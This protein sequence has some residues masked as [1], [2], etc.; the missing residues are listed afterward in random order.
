M[1]KNGIVMIAM[2]GG[3]D[4]A[5]SAAKLLESGYEVEG[6]HMTNWRDDEPYCTASQDLQDAKNACKEIGIPMHHVDFS[7]EYRKD[8]FDESLLELRSG[9]TPNPDILCNQMIKFDSF[10]QHAKRLGAKKIATGHYAR[11]SMK[12]DESLLLKG[13]DQNK[14]QTYFLH[15]IKASVLDDVLFPVGSMKKEEVRDYAYKKGLPNHDKPD[16]T[17]I[18]FIGERPFKNF[19]Q[20]FLPP[21]PGKIV[22]EDGETLGAHDGLMYF[23]L[24]QRKDIGIGGLKNHSGEPWYVASKNIDTNELLVVQGRNHKKLWQNQAFAKDMNW[25]NDDFRK[26]VLKGNPIACKAKCRYRQADA[27]CEIQLHKDGIRVVFDEDQW[28]ITH[29][30]YLVIYLNDVCMGGGKIFPEDQLTI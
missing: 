2:S 24:G 26:K 13:T 23:T 14:D 28:A 3:V 1:S 18:C 29:G 30:Q 20:T 16:S 9:L 5:V 11:T 6:L 15:G 7:N 19:I 25:L 27:K 21:E 12:N 8:V 22:T 17:G 4:S 10:I